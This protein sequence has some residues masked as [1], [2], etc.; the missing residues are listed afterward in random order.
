MVNAIGL[1]S[2]KIPGRR[3]TGRRPTGRRPSRRRPSRRRPSR[4]RPT[5]R[6]PS[7]RRP[8]GRRPTGRR[9]TGSSLRTVKINGTL[10][11]AP[12]GRLYEQLKLMGQITRLSLLLI[13]RRSNRTI[14]AISA[15]YHH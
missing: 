15:I 2:H 9:P 5:G 1:F 10:G 11:D 14:P 8:T 12:A 6:R 3:P 13:L 4:R 7:R